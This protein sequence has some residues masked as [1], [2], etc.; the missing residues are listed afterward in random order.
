MV[1]SM[2]IL[3]I[4][5]G[6]DHNRSSP[7]VLLLA[8]S[9]VN[10]W[11]LYLWTIPMIFTNILMKSYFRLCCAHGIESIISQNTYPNCAVLLKQHWLLSDE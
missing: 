10:L 7:R 9:L 8:S 6:Q 11:N 4:L 3:V 1:K 2:L 5:G